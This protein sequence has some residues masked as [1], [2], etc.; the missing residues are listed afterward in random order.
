MRRANSTVEPAENP[1]D[2]GPPA[3]Y[4]RQGDASSALPRFLPEI[5]AALPMADEPTPETYFQIQSEPGVTVVVPAKIVDSLQWEVI[6]GASSWILERA[7]VPTP[8]YLLF[9]MTEVE[10]FGS[11]FLSL[12]LR[13]GKRVTASGGK[14]AVCGLQSATR[15]VIDAAHL[16]K[17]WSIY[18]HRA[19]A[20]A[21]LA[22]G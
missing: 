19:A 3:D 14:F 2:A 1:I 10:Y 9:D 18:E 15:E 17:I 4:D 20:L 13:C 21:A 11:I 7:M 6:D 12:M 16:Y 8:P 5:P 22:E